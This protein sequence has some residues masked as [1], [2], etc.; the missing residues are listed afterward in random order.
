MKIQQPKEKKNHEQKPFKKNPTRVVDI[1]SL[2]RENI[3]KLIPYSSA[4]NKF[5]GETL[6]FLDANENSL[7]SPL[8]KAY[9]L[10]PDPIQKQLK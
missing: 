5:T 3:R 6:I 9:H 8:A 2:V 10:Y 4:R 7:G 1:S